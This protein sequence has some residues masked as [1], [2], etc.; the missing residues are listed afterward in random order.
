[1]NF[2][3]IHQQFIKRSKQRKS[4]R[5]RCQH[6]FL[7][8]YFSV[9]SLVFVSI[10][11][12]YQTLETVFDQFPNTSKFVKNPSLPVV[13]STL[14]SVF[15]N[16]VKHGLSCLK[17]YVK[18]V[19]RNLEGTQK[20]DLEG[21]QAMRSKNLPFIV[22]K[23]FCNVLLRKWPRTTLKFTIWAFAFSRVLISYHTRETRN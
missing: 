13:F 1:M 18:N 2:T 6:R 4:G 11:K 10:E 8:F 16:L 22:S 20:R 3:Q 7:R 17:Y 5:T 12:I 21:S 14:F 23:F 15:G 9:Y 19:R